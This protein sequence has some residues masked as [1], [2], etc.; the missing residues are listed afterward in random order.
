LGSPLIVCNEHHRFLVAEQ[1]C[2]INVAPSAIVLEPVGRNTAPAVAIAALLATADGS[3]PTLLVLP[4]DHVIADSTALH[5]AVATGAELARQGSLLTFGVVPDKAE[6]GYG[7]IRAD[8]SRGW[9]HLGHSADGTIDAA[10][11]AVAEFVEK[12][13]LTT[14]QAYVASGNYYWNSG[15]FMF[16]ASSFLKEL[17]KFAP[18][19][20]D[21]CRQSLAAA[22][23]DLDFTRLDAAA[24][25]ACPS[26]S[27]DYAV[28]EKT[29]NAVV[30]P[31]D[32]GW[33]DVGSWSALWETGSKDADGN[34]LRGDVL[35]KDTRSCYLHAGTRML[36]AVGVTDHVIVETGDAVLVAHKDRV[37]DV[38]AIV[39]QL[40]HEQ[41]HEA[42]IHRRVNRP[43]GDYECI[44]IAD[45]YQVK[46]I[47]VKPGAS[48]SL[49]MH[50]HRAEHWIVVRGTA[51]ITCGEE[52]RTVAEN[53][54]TYSPLGTAHRLEN[55]GK[56]PLE[57]IEVQSGSYL[58]ED[59]IVR[60]EDQ[61]GR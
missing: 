40:K 45:R 16:R 43:W 53:Q 21:A 36:A 2:Q 58:G 14:A 39:D 38:K 13:N 24:F 10:A 52:T 33:N 26:N 56:I 30:I 15:M 20:L 9:T 29:A 48:L 34:V 17:E 31:L 47:T 32:A 57:L 46:R 1:L 59:D 54:S 23:R 35:T 27:I 37:Q 19:I 61:Y 49:Q 11:Y 7:Y 50:Y 22:V 25:A 41:R 12:P 51:L 42:L 55:P 4:A 18:A 28:M 44:D 8:Q 5:T 3:D 6:T 60:F